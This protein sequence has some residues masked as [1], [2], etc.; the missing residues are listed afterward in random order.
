MNKFTKRVPKQKLYIEYVRSLNGLLHLT[1]KEILLV[2]ELIK[3][4]INYIK[5]KGI[6]KNIV[7]TQNRKYI[8]NAIGISK[9]NLSR[10][11]K[12]LKLKGLL[13]HD[14]ER[15]EITVNPALVPNIINDRV[16]ITLIIK[17]G[18]YDES[19]SG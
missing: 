12:K 2:T 5:L 17:T 16:Q 18:E 3:L 10:A 11:I 14:K 6:P 15:G 19:T 13:I 7:N 1:E 9:D 8:Q 4:D